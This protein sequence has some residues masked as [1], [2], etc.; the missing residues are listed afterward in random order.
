MSIKN[1]RHIKISHKFEFNF[2]NIDCLNG[3]LFICFTTVLVLFKELQSYTVHEL[4]K[5]NT[6][7]IHIFCATDSQSLLDYINTELVEGTSGINQ[8]IYISQVPYCVYP[9]IELPGSLYMFGSM[10]ADIHIYSQLHIVANIST[11]LIF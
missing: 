3:N 4:L 9:L 5:A 2:S 7:A 11:A 8:Q 10:K 6:S 1:Y